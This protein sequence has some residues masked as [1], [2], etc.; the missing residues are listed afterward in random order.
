MMLHIVNKVLLNIAT[1]LNLHIIYGASHY[2]AEL[3]IWPPKP[4]IVTLWSNV[5]TLML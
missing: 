3:S 2:K 4:T 5:E 1:P